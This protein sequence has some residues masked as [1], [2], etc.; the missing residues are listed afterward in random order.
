[1][2]CALVDDE[3]WR[4]GLARTLLEHGAH[5]DPRDWLGFTALHYACICRRPS[6]VRVLLA[7]DFDVR[8][9]DSRGNAALH[10][11]AVTG[12]CVITAA[13]LS[14]YRRYQLP[15]N[16][17][18]RAGQ[19]ALEFAIHNGHSDCVHMIRDA[20]EATISAD[21]NGKSFSEPKLSDDLLTTPAR[22]SSVTH[23]GMRFKIFVTER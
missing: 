23:K 21:I 16:A 22:T 4:V 6:L 19:T 5:S 14:T 10:Y 13:L 17:V 15:A 12:D 1:M 9:A 8:A 18:N 7:A 3:R 2:N 20:Q 11:A